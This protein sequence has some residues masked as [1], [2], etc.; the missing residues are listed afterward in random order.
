MAD[1]IRQMASRAQGSSYLS[2]ASY[3]FEPHDINTSLGHLF[4]QKQ[5]DAQRHTMLITAAKAL[6]LS[7]EK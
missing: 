7:A 4:L 3:D 1:E 5:R 2:K 6:G